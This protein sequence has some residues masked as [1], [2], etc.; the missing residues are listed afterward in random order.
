[1]RFL[2]RPAAVPDWVRE[3]VLDKK[4]RMLAASEALDGTWLVATRSRLLVAAE[5][6]ESG[7]AAR[8]RQ[9][10][11]LPFR[12]E[13]VHRADWNQDLAVLSVE[14]VEDYGRPVTRHS[15]ELPEPGSLLDVVRERVSASVLVQRRVEVAGKRGLTVIAR[16]APSEDGEV[17]WS[18]QF[19]PGMDPT[20]PGVMAAAESGLQDAKESLG[21]P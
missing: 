16:R 3:G 21:L 7:D 18:Y 12:W 14:R 4:E 5:L 10:T 2:P 9:A 11:V 20:D 19:D 17:R 15:F 1:M 6:E 13:D 8:A